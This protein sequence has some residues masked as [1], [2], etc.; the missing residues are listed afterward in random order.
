VV[1]VSRYSAEKIV[2]LYDVA[3]S[4]VRVVPNGVDTQRFKPAEDCEEVERQLGIDDKQCVLFVGRLIPRK[5]LHFLAEAA[6]RIVKERAETMFLIVGEGPFKNPMISRLKQTG[7]LGNFVFLGDVSEALL[8]SLYRCADV[9]AFPSIQEG[10]GIAL[11]EAQATAKPVVAFNRGGV[12]EAVKHGQTGLLV[13]PN[14]QELADA[15]LRLLSDTDLS[16][17]MG[18]EGR[19]FVSDN[20]SWETCAERMLQVYHEAISANK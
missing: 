1:T 15:I 4:R 7:L 2:Q 3:E 16:E 17:R 11:L 18:E 14:S 10:L 13:K 19:R 12:R 9:F 5:G 8:P 6:K 20:F